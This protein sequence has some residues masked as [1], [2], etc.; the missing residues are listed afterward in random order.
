MGAGLLQGLPHCFGVTLGPPCALAQGGPCLCSVDSLSRFHWC[1][2]LVSQCICLGWASAC[3]VFFFRCLVLRFWASLFPCHLSCL[4][5]SRESWTCSLSVLFVSMGVMLF[6]AFCTW[7]R[8]QTLDLM[9]SIHFFLWSSGTILVLFS[10]P[11]CFIK[12]HF[13]I[14][15]IKISG[16]QLVPGERETK[17]KSWAPVFELRYAGI[18]AWVSF[19]S[20]PDDSDVHLGWEPL[21]QVSLTMFPFTEVL[22]QYKWPNEIS[23]LW[24]HGVVSLLIVPSAVIKGLWSRLD[25]LIHGADT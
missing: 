2:L 9:F 8:I 1:L 13:Y 20:S 10:F 3:L 12:C 23:P 14:L 16:L 21:V 22:F 18:Q 25:R 5:D 11:L 15:H 4:I 19:T 6:S 7:S 24:L 17:Y